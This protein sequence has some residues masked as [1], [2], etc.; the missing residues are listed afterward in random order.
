MSINPPTPNNGLP[1]AA[2]SPLSLQGHSLN[3]G[4]LTCN[5]GQWSNISQVIRTQFQ[6]QNLV[7]FQ[8][9]SRGIWSNPTGIGWQ[10]QRSGVFNS[11]AAFMD[12][13]VFEDFVGN[14][15]LL[16]QVGNTVYS[17]NLTT[18][19]ETAYNAPLNS[20]STSLANLPCMRSFL[21]NT[22]QAAPVTIYCNGAIQPQQITGTAAADVVALPFVANGS[23]SSSNPTGGQFGVDYSVS[24]FTPGTF[25]ASYATSPIT[26]PLLCILNPNDGNIYFVTSG[27]MGK[28]TPLGIVTVVATIS[29]HLPTGICIGPDAR[30]WVCF[31]SVASFQAVT[32]AG[33]VTTYSINS[34]LTTATGIATDGTNIVVGFSSPA[35][36]QRYTTSGVF[37]ANTSTTRAVSSLCFGPDGRFWSTTNGNFIQ[38][39][40]LGGATTTYT[41]GLNSASVGANI[42]S[43]IGAT[44]YFADTGTNQI[45]VI[46]TAGTIQEFNIPSNGIPPGF[47]TVG[48]D[49]NIWFTQLG[50]TLIGKLTVATNSIVMFSGPPV[51]A[52]LQAIAT[53]ADG[54]L[55]FCMD[56]LNAIGT[57]LVS[58]VGIR[59]IT[60]GPDGRIWFCCYATNSIGALT[61]SGILSQY[62][63]PI[64]GSGP[65]DICSDGTN[66]WFTAQLGNY[67]GKITTAGVVTSF[68]LTTAQSLPTGICFN[69]GDGNIWFTEYNNNK[70]AKITPGGSITEFSV[71]T[72]TSG[73]YGI[74]SNGTLLFF[75]ESLTNKINECTTSGSQTEFVVP[76]ASSTPLWIALGSDARLWFTENTGNKIGAMTTGGTFT[77]YIIPTSNSQPEQITPASDGNLYFTEAAADNIGRITIKG[78]ITEFPIDI[79]NAEPF[80]IVDGPDQSIWFSMNGV[81]EV[82]NFLYGGSGT[83][84]G[85]F[86]LTK[87]TYSMPQFCCYFN[88][89]MAYFGFAPGSNA[90]LDVLISN[91]G[92]S[93]SFETNAPIQATDAVS[94]TIPGLGLPTGMAAFR[95]TN[96]NNQE[97]LI[98]G[99]QRGIAVVMG[100]GVTS[101]ATT[102][103]A[104]ILT[105]EFGLMS[106]RSFAQIQND[107]HFL[108]TNGW[109]SFS[110]LTINANLLNAALTYQMQDVIASITPVPVTGT[111]ILYNA[112]A[113]A[114]HHRDTLEVQFWFPTT[115]DQVGSIYENQHGI[116]M[117]YNSLNPTPQQ[118]TPIFSQKNGTAIS[119]GIEF[120]GVMY[121]GGYDGRLQQHYTGNTYNGAAIQGQIQ[122]ALI[123]APNVQQ[124]ME[125]RQG[126]IICEGESAQNFNVEAYFYSKT[127]NGTL[128]RTASP[129]GV[130][131]LTALSSSGFINQ[132]YFEAG[133]SG[134]YIEFDLTTNGTSQCLDFAGLEWTG[135]VGGLRP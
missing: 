127:Q 60:S 65:F 30:I 129:E 109:R 29:A 62:P 85:V 3:Q 49:G 121:G 131:N 124:S 84:P 31:S 5:E 45:G 22:G 105:Y 98:L 91:Q 55:W 78:I 77:E 44:L 15:T 111:N 135:T 50:G 14:Q 52:D 73:P 1:P 11:G 46:T 88:N 101:D 32:P 24:N 79:T 116:I 21:D 87:K 39:T 25:V 133:G 18:S 2:Y 132:V 9:L 63:L 83:W 119:C 56:G 26:S 54:N 74:C 36:L 43:G 99:Y 67:I 64:A 82:G 103:A 4:L 38:A 93:G 61:P 110:N 42:I 86:Q 107:I 68:A 34:S 28:I 97:V 35:G 126:I 122:L 40:V 16:F 94:F 96:T 117:N 10:P 81:P 89:R 47:L 72:A 104:D 48:S 106:N 115:A 113:F 114:V 7:N 27:S 41:T 100:N 102:Y 128:V 69:S 23:Q 118:L 57:M 17:Y 120:M 12:F 19:T 125:L 37:G 75:C 90:A 112:Q 108:S 92:L 71:T 51:G 76:T 134:Q 53:G 8:M 66:L 59:G 20:L 130:Q 33:V 13:G 6:A 80:G 58:T 123:S 95:L 70:V